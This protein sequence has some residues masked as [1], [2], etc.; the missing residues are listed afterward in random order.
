MFQDFYP[1][2]TDATTATVTDSKF[3]KIDDDVP[4]RFNPRYIRTTPKMS[5]SRRFDEETGL[6]ELKTVEKQLF[7]DHTVVEAAVGR[8]TG[9][10]LG[11]F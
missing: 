8:N 9:G 2:E 6:I 5:S 7:L 1:P 10:S 11:H 4:V 3:G